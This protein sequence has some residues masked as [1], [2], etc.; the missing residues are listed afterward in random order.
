MS[1]GRP[2]TPDERRRVVELH[3]EL[4]DNGL[5]ALRLGLSRRAVATVLRETARAEKGAPRG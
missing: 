5:V 3:A 1:R 4:G 2:L